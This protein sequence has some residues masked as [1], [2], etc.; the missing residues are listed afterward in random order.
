M[1]ILVFSVFLLLGVGNSSENHQ[2]L[3][4]ANSCSRPEVLVESRNLK[5]SLLALRLPVAPHC[6][7]GPSKH[8]GR[9]PDSVQSGPCLLHRYTLMFEALTGQNREILE[10]I[11]AG[12]SG[13]SKMFVVP[14]TV[15]LYFSPPIYLR[16]PSRLYC[17]LFPSVC[18]H[19]L[20]AS[21]SLGFVPIHVPQDLSIIPHP[22]HLGLPQWVCKFGGWAEFAL[23]G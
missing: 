18:W 1:I 10:L 3:V 8:P 13:S 16:N 19:C 6:P 9:V 5:Q 22:H 11:L 14:L 17:P 21:H 15:L 4:C 23:C 7:L 12:F 2:C 20:F